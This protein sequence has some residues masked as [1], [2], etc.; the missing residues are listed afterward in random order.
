MK[1]GNGVTVDVELGRDT[2]SSAP[3]AGLVIV[4]FLIVILQQRVVHQGI[5]RELQENRKAKM[6]VNAIM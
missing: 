3:G 5:L 1:R 2:S 6:P 4:I